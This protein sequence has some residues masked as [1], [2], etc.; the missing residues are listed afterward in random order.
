MGIEVNSFRGVA[1]FCLA[2]TNPGFAAVSS[3][4]SIFNHQRSK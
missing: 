1:R 4:S 3:S 2:L